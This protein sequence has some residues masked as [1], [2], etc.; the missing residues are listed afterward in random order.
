MRLTVGG[1]VYSLISVIINI[2]MLHR[3]V[4]SLASALLL[5]LSAVQGAEGKPNIVLFFADDLGWAGLNCFGSDLYET[6]N[7]DKLAATGMKFTDAYA[8]CTVCSPSRAA[9][10]T[11]MY[12][13]SHTRA[14]ESY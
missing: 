5:S 9:L 7:L 12:P 2:R 13:A 14:N 1:N 11:G 6:P 10:L 4:Y 8:A 3:L